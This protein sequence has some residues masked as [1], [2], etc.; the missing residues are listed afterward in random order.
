MWD[1]QELLRTLAAVAALR[2]AELRSLF[3]LEQAPGLS[4][5][6]AVA[7]REGALASARSLL[8]RHINSVQQNKEKLWSAL[9]PQSGSLKRRYQCNCR[10]RFVRSYQLMTGGSPCSVHEIRQQYLWLTLFGLP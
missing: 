7:E 1:L 10:Q 2:K 3:R 9:T 8:M 4:Q 6:L 5:R